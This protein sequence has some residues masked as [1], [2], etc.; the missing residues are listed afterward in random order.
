M[1]HLGYLTI[2]LGG[3]FD[4][5]AKAARRVYNLDI[6]HT[7]TDLWRRAFVDKVQAVLL[8]AC[9]ALAND[10]ADATRWERR[11]CFCQLMRLTF[12]AF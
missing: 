3:M 9:F 6:K 7:D 11:G 2:L 4:T 10:V 12:G 5:L 8:E 1:Y